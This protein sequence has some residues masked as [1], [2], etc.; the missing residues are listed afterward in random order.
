MNADA[1]D[2]GASLHAT[3]A[4]ASGAWASLLATDRR[5]VRRMGVV[6]RDG[7]PLSNPT[8][9]RRRPLLMDAFAQH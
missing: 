5:R 9:G 4:V 1:T 8:A 3:G 6:A 2:A 7:S